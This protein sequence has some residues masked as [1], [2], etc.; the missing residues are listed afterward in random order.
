[1][2]KW[3][4]LSII[5]LMGILLVGCKKVHTIDETLDR[6]AIGMSKTY[7]DVYSSEYD[8][9]SNTIILTEDEYKT[10]YLRLPEDNR[11]EFRYLYMSH[12]ASPL[13]GMKDKSSYIQIND[14]K[15]NELFKFN[16]QE[17]K[18]NNIPSEIY[19]QEFVDIV[20]KAQ[21]STEKHKSLSEF[22][23]AMRN[24]LGENFERNEYDKNED[25]YIVKL[26]STEN[27]ME[28]RIA[29]VLKLYSSN[30][31][32]DLTVKIY[33]SDNTKLAEIKDTKIV[34]YNT[35]IF[36]DDFLS[37]GQEEVER[38]NDLNYS[39]NKRLKELE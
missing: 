13:F 39:V 6:I 20:G 22:E 36:D 17:V 34:N 9:D 32:S 2:K 29:R 18:T 26:K 38:V 7:L 10:P 31:P 19:G 37:I 24:V 12:L 28:S 21:A 11:N 27:H 15:G 5:G 35:E 1:M 3:I 33:S 14:S 4:E 25:A 16:N 23:N 30:A 8:Y